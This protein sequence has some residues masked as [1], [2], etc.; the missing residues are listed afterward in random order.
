MP[1]FPSDDMT[2]ADIAGGVTEMILHDIRVN[3]LGLNGVPQ[4]SVD[5]KDGDEF[6]ITL[7]WHGRNNGAEKFSLPRSKVKAIAHTFKASGEY[8][9]EEFELVQRAL[10]ALEA[11]S[12]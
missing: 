5:T 2:S 9:K 8:E 12:E 10:A 3:L 11:S 4:V 7:S 1:H 6:I